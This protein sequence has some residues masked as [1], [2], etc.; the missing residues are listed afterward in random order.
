M[1]RQSPQITHPQRDP[2]R[3]TGLRASLARRARQTKMMQAISR[4]IGS[5]LVAAAYKTT[6]TQP[7]T[8]AN[9]TQSREASHASGKNRMRP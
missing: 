4:T 9:D 8:H 7:P 5:L 1:E 6:N 3:L 2:I